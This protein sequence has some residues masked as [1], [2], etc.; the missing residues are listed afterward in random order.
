MPYEDF[1]IL[2]LSPSSIAASTQILAKICENYHKSTTITHIE[3]IIYS[4][5]SKHELYFP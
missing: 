2:T 4:P 3:S 1:T 5:S